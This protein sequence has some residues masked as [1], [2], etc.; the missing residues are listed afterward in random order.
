MSLKRNILIIF[1]LILSG[2]AVRAQ[3]A[4]QSL[5]LQ[6]VPAAR[7]GV[8]GQLPQGA[9]QVVTVVHRLSGIKLLR[10]LRRTEASA[11]GVT[12]LDERFAA[13][14]EMHTSVL[15]GLLLGDGRTIV[16]RLPQA[17]AEV[18]SPMWV[19]PSV[20]VTPEIS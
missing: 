12:D 9:P 14:K 6:P 20:S 5:A 2:A 4:G 18:E 11:S 3:N 1:C 13:T 7:A 16:T 19:E 15:A 17:E 8:S 10:L